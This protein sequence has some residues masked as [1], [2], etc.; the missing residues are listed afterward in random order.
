MVQDRTTGVVARKSPHDR[1]F[2][3]APNNRAT[4]R[5]HGVASARRKR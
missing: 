1:K 3:F 5:P 4:D 2:C